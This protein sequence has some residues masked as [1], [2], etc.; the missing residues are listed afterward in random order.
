MSV[1]GGESDARRERRV[2]NP[3]PTRL[4]SACESAISDSVIVLAGSIGCVNA[5][6]LYDSPSVPRAGHV[7]GKGIALEVIAKAELTAK[8]WSSRVD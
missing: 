5:F 7:L 4:L 1:G 6:H 3:V 2:R 8:A